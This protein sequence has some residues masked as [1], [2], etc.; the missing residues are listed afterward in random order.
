MRMIG[1]LLWCF[2]FLAYPQPAW[3]LKLL[4]AGLTR[5]TL[6][7]LTKHEKPVKHHWSSLRS[8][9]PLSTE[10]PNKS[11]TERRLGWRTT[12]SPGS[13][14]WR[15]QG[16]QG[17]VAGHTVGRGK[18]IPGAELRRATLSGL[19]LHRTA[20]Q[21]KS[22]PSHRGSML[23]WTALL[24]SRGTEC[25]NRL[26]EQVSNKWQRPYDATGKSHV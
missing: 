6:S 5:E 15:G 2:S 25:A 23:L 13:L 1:V 3:F 7:E 11:S 10:M 17:G 22:P 19:K 24:R 26:K 12:L 16:V 4:S 20:L 8:H 21:A 9:S 18:Q 14:W